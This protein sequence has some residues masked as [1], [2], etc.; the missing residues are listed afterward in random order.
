MH[1]NF[2]NFE[3]AVYTD[4]RSVAPLLFITL[5]LRNCSLFLPISPSHEACALTWHSRAATKTTQNIP[6]LSLVIRLRA[7]ISQVLNTFQLDDVKF[8]MAKFW[9]FSSHTPL[10]CSILYL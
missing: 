9:L 1:D 5:T 3:R 7:I 4:Y 6:K 8:L 10:C 2:F